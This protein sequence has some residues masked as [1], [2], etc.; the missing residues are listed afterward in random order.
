MTGKI[1][2][3]NTAKT[4]VHGSG[5]ILVIGSNTAP[6]PAAPP[7]PGDDG[8]SNDPNSYEATMRVILASGTDYFSAFGPIG[9]DQVIYTPDG[10]PSP[11]IVSAAPR[12]DAAYIHWPNFGVH[13]CSMS[14][15]LTAFGIAPFMLQWH[16]NINIGRSLLHRGWIP[17]M[18]QI[19]VPIVCSAILLA[20]A[21]P[22]DPFT[23]SVSPWRGYNRWVATAQ[24]LMVRTT[25][26][27][28]EFLLHT[29]VPT[30][31]NV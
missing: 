31:K 20:R 4:Q 15:Q 25:E 11:D 21:Q 7:G 26:A 2:V 8:G 30:H 12:S 28:S 27:G 29:S 10:G 1:V 17:H 23:S 22:M 6:P 19:Q 14:T 9:S 5:S 3:A 18:V 13:P 24:P 16:L